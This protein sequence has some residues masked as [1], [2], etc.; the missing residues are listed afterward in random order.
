[1]C[2]FIIL[3]IRYNHSKHF[4]CDLFEFWGPDFKFYNWFKANN[5]TTRVAWAIKRE[6]PPQYLWNNHNKQGKGDK[7]AIKP[8]QN[9][10]FRKTFF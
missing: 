3:A 8:L 10:Q 9:I 7:N 5:L 1:M 2:S 4:F 6:K